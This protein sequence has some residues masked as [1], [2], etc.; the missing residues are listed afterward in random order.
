MT[1]AGEFCGKQTRKNSDGVLSLHDN[2]AMYTV[3]LFKFTLKPRFIEIDHLPY[4]PDQA[5]SGNF[6]PILKSDLR[7]KKLTMTSIELKT[8]PRSVFAEVNRL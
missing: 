6:F 4:S 7:D 5:T 3:G 1:V 8:E 2:A